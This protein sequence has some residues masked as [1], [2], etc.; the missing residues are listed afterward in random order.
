MCKLFPGSTLRDG[1]FYLT[2]SA[3]RT[4]GDRFAP[5]WTSFEA[6][7]VVRRVC[8]ALLEGFGS[9]LKGEILA[10]IGRMFFF[11]AF[12][13]NFALPPDERKLFDGNR[14]RFLGG[15]TPRYTMST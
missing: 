1:G 12:I 15:V 11:S 3:H 7:A 5:E 10:P 9:L 6:N 14:L 2:V 13:S 4:R 8:G